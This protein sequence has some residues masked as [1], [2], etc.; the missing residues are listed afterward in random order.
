MKAIMNCLN[1]NKETEDRKYCDH[2]CQN[3]FR[4]KRH[5]RNMKLKAIEYKGGKC[6]RCGY[7][8]SVYALTFHHKDP[9]E[10]DFGIGGDGGTKAWEK[11]R[12]ELDKCVLLCANCH[13]EE[14]EK[15]DK[16][17]PVKLT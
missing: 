15:I 8:K 11:I 13:A 9:N 12:I 5:R 2:K 3:N 16:Q 6:E 17:T 4:V 14:H 1:C 10:K 7:D